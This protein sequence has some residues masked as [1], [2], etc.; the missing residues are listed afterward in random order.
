MSSQYVLGPDS[1]YNT[2]Y[3]SYVSRL[4]VMI[5]M[6]WRAKVKELY[7]KEE[8]EYLMKLYRQT[9]ML[10]FRT[11]VNPFPLQVIGNRYEEPVKV[12]RCIVCGR[13]F[14]GYKPGECDA[15]TSALIREIEE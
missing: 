3:S 1:Y 4:N 11:D 13:A 9:G 15:C 14:E 10:F 6:I 8:R 12:Y 5:E 2:L 7:D